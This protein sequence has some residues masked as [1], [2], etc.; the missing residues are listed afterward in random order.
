M[1]NRKSEDL[2]LSEDE[3]YALLSLCLTSP[4]RLDSTSEKALRKLAKFCTESSNHH[5]NNEVQLQPVGA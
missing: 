1:I 2:M 3:A 5:N 4:N